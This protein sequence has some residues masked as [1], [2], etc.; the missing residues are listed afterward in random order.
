MIC[1]LD[2]IPGF[3]PSSVNAGCGSQ[4]LEIAILAVIVNFLIRIFIWMFAHAFSLQDVE[5]N[6]KAEMLQ[7][8]ATA[9]MII[10]IIAMVQ[11]AETFAI[12]NVFGS[13]ESYVECGGSQIAVESM[14]SSLDVVK[15]RVM[16]R[17]YSIAELQNSIY[18]VNGDVDNVFRALSTYVG[19]AGLPVFQGN[20]VSSW[21][22]AA[23][24]YKLL[25]TMTTNLLIS[26]NGIIVFV[27][28][29]SSN[30]L[31]WF[32]PIGLILRS[33]QQTRGIGALFISLAI[34]FYFIFPII[35]V[36]TDPGFHKI[37]LPAITVA[38]PDSQLCYPT[39]SGVATYVSEGS[40]GSD[41]FSASLGGITQA[42]LI[43]Q[44][45][46]TS[47]LIQP[48]IALGI[49]LIF[50]RY[51]IYILGGEPYEIMR[52]VAKMV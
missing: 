28:Y 8:S 5:K 1:P 4:W 6:A 37:D 39:F 25:N 44:R 30:M 36:I 24:S 46:Y 19:L 51:L 14:T 21:Y 7:T 20:Y 43:L 17:A 13:Q 31:A 16:E 41:S 42:K 45:V 27:N 40:S 11:G 2:L 52:A 22:N 50:V 29:V 26:L 12:F 47:I 32:L 3:T 18:E 15:C 48:Y 9:L 49:T 34:G 10:F 38:N 23:E 35:F 33:F